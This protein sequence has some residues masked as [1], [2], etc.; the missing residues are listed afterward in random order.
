M[1]SLLV[2][3]GYLYL[4]QNTFSISWAL[5]GIF[6]MKLFIEN[7]KIVPRVH[8]FCGPFADCFYSLTD[9][10]LGTTAVPIAAAQR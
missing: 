4:E 1:F 7:G 2:S 6:L 10:S 3:S 5:L 8:W 9:Y